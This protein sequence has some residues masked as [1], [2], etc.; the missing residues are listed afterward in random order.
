M[1]TF[2]YYLNY[3]RIIRAIEMFT[4][5]KENIEKVGYTVGYNTLSNFSRTFKRF[6]GQSPKS[7]IKNNKTTLPQQ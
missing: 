4:D 5:H 2:N 3:V 7:F 6:T 1:M